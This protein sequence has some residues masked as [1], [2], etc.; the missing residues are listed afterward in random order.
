M[1]DPPPWGAAIMFLHDAN[2]SS[3]DSNPPPS[4]ERRP[5][6]TSKPEARPVN[7]WATLAGRLKSSRVGESESESEWRSFLPSSVQ[8]WGGLVLTEIGAPWPPPSSEA[9]GGDTVSETF[10][11]YRE[12]P[13]L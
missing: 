2:H 10:D 13:G 3:T 5:T 9:S 6:K 11:G 7:I 1:K 12:V 8:V 4:P